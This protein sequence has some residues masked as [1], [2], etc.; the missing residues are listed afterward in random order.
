MTNDEI[1]DINTKIE[2]LEG[3]IANLPEGM[4]AEVKEEASNALKKEIEKLKEQKKSAEESK[5][6]EIKPQEEDIDKNK[7]AS[8][9]SKSILDN[10]MQSAEYSIVVG[11]YG[12][13]TLVYKNLKNGNFV[14]VERPDADNYVVSAKDSS[15]NK[16]VADKEDLINIIKAMQQD[17]KTSISLGT[18]KSQEF[19][20]RLV[21]AAQ[22]CNMPISNLTEKRQELLSQAKLSETDGMKQE[23]VPE[24]VASQEIAPQE[25]NDQDFMSAKEMLEHN[26]DLASDIRSTTKEVAEKKVAQGLDALAK[27]TDKDMNPNKYEEFKKTEEYNGLTKKQKS[28]L[29]ATVVLQQA[30]KDGKISDKDRRYL[31]TMT[32]LGRDYKATLD[33]AYKK[34]G[35]D[36]ENKNRQIISQRFVSQ[37]KAYQGQSM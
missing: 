33:R 11:D 24:N 1:N 4:S 23:E 13:D 32:K 16:K 12:K 34:G 8:Q 18:V 9:T 22:E 28:I 7:P 2:Q 30:A 5:L 14:S 6:N 27:V 26:I 10:I 15:G 29:D 36:R 17:G 37:V 3:M 20:D 35:D 31:N 25:V 19:L 21:A